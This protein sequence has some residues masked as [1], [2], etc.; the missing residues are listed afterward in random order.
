MKTYKNKR[1]QEIMTYR[2]GCMIVDR[3]VIEG[4][5]DLDCWEEVI[6][7][8]YEII[9]ILGKITESLYVLNRETGL[10]SNKALFKNFS[11]HELLKKDCEIN[12]IERLSDGVVFT[13]GDRVRISKLKHDGSFVISE[14]YFDRT[15][16]N[17]LCGGVIAG[18]G[19][20]NI[21]KI[22]HS[23]IP[24]FKTEDGVDIFEGDAYWCVNTAPH[25]WSIFQ[26]TAKERTKLNKTV[27]AFK[28]VNL[29]QKYFDKN[30]P[31]FTTSD[32]V[33]IFLGDTCWVVSKEYNFQIANYRINNI[34]MFHIPAKN[35][36]FSKKKKAEEYIT[37][38]KPCLSLNDIKSAINLHTVQL[39]NLQELIKTKII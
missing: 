3:S 28:D 23:A 26:Q 38:N 15:N 36:Y 22:E 37:M 1:T 20:V 34:D 10:Y 12:S 4:K 5:P 13:I 6:E 16:T 33:E 31:L 25:L 9:S 17:L 7:K 18:N 30:K 29:A 11:A 24:L 8:N 27:I 14:F 21:T 19:H 35:W 2:D 39:G 32:G